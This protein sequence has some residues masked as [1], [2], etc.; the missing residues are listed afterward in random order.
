MSEPVLIDQVE[1]ATAATNA[2]AVRD[3]EKAVL[4]ATLRPIVERAGIYAGRV[5]AAIVTDQT[6]ADALIELRAEIDT[7]A[8]NAEAAVTEYSGGLIDRLHKLHRGW[9]GLR[10]LICDPLAVASK[11][12]KRKVIDWQEAERL[13]AEAEQRRLQAR[14]DELARLERERLEKAAA[15]LKT[16]E[17]REARMEQAAQVIAP[18]VTVEAPL[19]CPSSSSPSPVTRPRARRRA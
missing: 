19:D 17:L 18:T 4:I 15:K 9:T 8:K 5:A 16:P 2:L 10:G 12:A 13:K 3:E 14:A 1:K 11:A 7:D 6:S